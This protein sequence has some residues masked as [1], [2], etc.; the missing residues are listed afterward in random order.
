MTGFTIIRDLGGGGVN[1]HCAMLSIKT[2]VKGP[3]V[4]TAGENLLLPPRVVRRST[5]NGY[6]K[7][8]MGDR[9]CCRVANGRMSVC[10][11]FVNVIRW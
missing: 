3:D 10:R 9:T 4:F 8:L 1:I 5:T 7:D 2:L 6:R 11:L